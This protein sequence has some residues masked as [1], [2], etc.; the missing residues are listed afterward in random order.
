MWCHDNP[1]NSINVGWTILPTFEALR[2]PDDLTQATL[3]VPQGTK[4]LYQNTTPWSNF[5]T[6]NDGTTTTTNI[7]HQH[8]VSQLKNFLQQQSA[9][10]GITNGRMLGLTNNDMAEWDNNETWITKVRDLAWNNDNPKRISKV[11]WF[12]NIFG[13]QLAGNLDMSDCIA[14]TTLWC[15]EN[16]LTT[17]NVSNCT[18]LTA[19]DCYGNKIT[20]INLQNCTQITRLQCHLNPLNNM[21]VSWTIL[22]VFNRF[23]LPSDLTQATLHLPQGTKSLYQNTTTW[24]KFGY[25]TEW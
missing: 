12:Y 5:G 13:Q 1:I 24:S 21:T 10:T 11:E 23:S 2:I 22:P 17:V 7:Y 16:Q 18:A 15:E 8:D 9:T 19:L 25:F 3:H 6:I 14:L 20:T 4:Q